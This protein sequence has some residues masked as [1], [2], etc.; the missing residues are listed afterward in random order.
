[1][2]IILFTKL[3]E[4]DEIINYC[5]TTVYEFNP[6]ITTNIIYFKGVLLHSLSF[7]NQFE[8]NYLSKTSNIIVILDKPLISRLLNYK[9]HHIIIQTEYFYENEIS[10]IKSHYTIQ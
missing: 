3:V 4:E 10:E 7:I 2:N 1:M 8:S 9:S 5:K 6:N